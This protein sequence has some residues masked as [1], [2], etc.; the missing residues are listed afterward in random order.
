MALLT[1]TGTAAAAERGCANTAPGATLARIDSLPSQQLAADLCSKGPV[2]TAALGCWIGAS[3][4]TCASDGGAW[5]DGEWLQGSRSYDGEWLQGGVDSGATLQSCCEHCHALPACNFFDLSST[6]SCRLMASRTTRHAASPLHTAGRVGGGEWGWASGAPLLPSDFSAWGKRPARMYLSKPIAGAACALL[7]PATDAAHRG[8]WVWTEVPCSLQR[9]AICRVAAHAH[10]RPPLPPLP[11]PPP[12]SPSPPPPPPNPFP[13]PSPPPP[14]PPPPPPSSPRPPA[15]PCSPPTPPSPPPPPPPPPGVT[16]SLYGV[17]TLY[18]A[19]GGAVVSAEGMVEQEAV[20]RSS[21]LRGCTSGQP[22]DTGEPRC[23][24]TCSAASYAWDCSFCRCQ[25]CAFCAAPAAAVVPGSR[26]W[27]VAEAEVRGTGLDISLLWCPGGCEF[28]VE[29]LHITGWE[30]LSLSSGVVMTPPLE[31]LADGSARLQLE[32][33]ATHSAQ[34]AETLGS[35]CLD[36]LTAALAHVLSGYQDGGARATAQ[37]LQARLTL[38]EVREG[39]RYI[40]FDISE[41]WPGEPRVEQLQQ[42]ML[43]LV[44]DT[45][46]ALYAPDKR[47]TRAVN[48]GGGVWRLAGSGAAAPVSLPT[49]EMA[50]LQLL[51]HRSAASL[52]AHTALWGMIAAVV[53]LLMAVML[54][55]LFRRIAADRSKGQHQALR[56]SEEEDATPLRVR[57]IYPDADAPPQLR[58][59]LAPP[60]PPPG[61]PPVE[62]SQPGLQQSF[63]GGTV[64]TLGPTP[65]SAQARPLSAAEQ[66]CFCIDSESYDGAGHGTAEEHQLSDAGRA[67]LAAATTR[68]YEGGA[69]ATLGGMTEEEAHLE[70]LE[71]SRCE[72]AERAAS[73]TASLAAAATGALTSGPPRVSQPSPPSVLLPLPPPPP[74]VTAP[75]PDSAAIALPDEMHTSDADLL[76]QMRWMREE[77]QEQGSALPPNGAG[78]AGSSAG[79]AEREEQGPDAMVRAGFEARQRQIE[80]QLSAG[81]APPASSV[82]EVRDYLMMQLP[83]VELALLY[84]QYTALYL[85]PATA[86]PLR[87]MAEMVVIRLGELVSKPQALRMQQVERIRDERRRAGCSELPLSTATGGVLGTGV[88]AGAFG[89]DDITQL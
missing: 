24:P 32:R 81:G 49:A 69:G 19:P 64:L 67:A 8:K 40:T 65:G 53:V 57:R 74:A 75:L 11:P 52:S 88:G 36:D 85:N 27:R 6:G 82:Y 34:S 89:D 54:C 21:V 18:A 39:G 15:P 41:G 68:V 80:T 14:S 76:Q 5:Y 83:E 44:A 84:E 87:A 3:D 73:L 7:A 31:P 48:A 20:P 50:R 63:T 1:L 13:H 45:R 37:A 17:V 61:L 59:M 42:L 70:A 33:R 28:K 9:A 56:T 38:A 72:D 46:S 22:H 71:R 35:L 29:P 16:V 26:A 10:P 43:A 78:V 25:R 4:R 12:P 62:P 66:M 86:A 51:A 30:H 2:G 60:P 58:Q 55:K 79:G 77:A 23:D 47:C